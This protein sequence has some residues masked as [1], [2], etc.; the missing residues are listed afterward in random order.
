MTIEFIL[1]VLVCICIGIVYAVFGYKVTDLFTDG[2]GW[3]PWE[4]VLFWLF[5]PVII[6]LFLFMA[7]L[8]V[9][10]GLLIPVLFVIGLIV[11]LIRKLFN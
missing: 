8:F 11:R 7:I 9:A 5:W 4:Q 10:F 2:P 6:P 3:K 1:S